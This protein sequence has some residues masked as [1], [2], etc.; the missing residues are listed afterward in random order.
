MKQWYA[1]YVS[2]Y[3]CWENICKFVF[4][5]SRSHMAETFQSLLCDGRSVAVV[6]KISHVLGNNCDIVF[7]SLSQQI[8]QRVTLP[9]S[10]CFIDT[11]KGILVVVKLWNSLWKFPTFSVTLTHATGPSHFVNALQ[12][13]WSSWIHY[14][15]P[16]LVNKWHDRHR[17]LSIHHV[18]YLMIFGSPR[19]CRKT[20]RRYSGTRW[21]SDS[22]VFNYDT[23]GG[24]FIIFIYV[25]SYQYCNFR[26]LIR[27]SY[28][29]HF[30]LSPH[31]DYLYRYLR[32]RYRADPRFASGQWETSLQSNDVSHWLD[33][34][35]DSGNNCRLPPG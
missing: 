34:S 8:V 33:T 17:Y 5:N 22:F 13:H 9:C 30:F 32:Y 10:C 29:P 25:S 23:R 15:H 26:W 35:P 19:H 31:W 7:I 3:S 24:H 20:L 4:E 16:S 21:H 11:V 12:V 2:L 27:R 6:K 28:N 1:L 14:I 18:P